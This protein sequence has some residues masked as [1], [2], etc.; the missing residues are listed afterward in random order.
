MVQ[1]S[2]WSAAQFSSIVLE[3]P[4][5]L[6]TTVPKGGVSGLEILTSAR[7]SLERHIRNLFRPNCERCL[8]KRHNRIPLFQDQTLL[9]LI[10]FPTLST[11]LLF[12][13]LFTPRAPSSLLNNC[14]SWLRPT[15]PTSRKLTLI[16]AILARSLSVTAMPNGHT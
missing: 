12:S 9:G 11:P 8:E 6:Y 15:P 5:H 7:T 3:C 16:P 4:A 13:I 1:D 14:S 10:T 2:N